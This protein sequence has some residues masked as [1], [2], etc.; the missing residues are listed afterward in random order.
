MV[1]KYCCPKPLY[2]QVNILIVGSKD[3]WLCKPKN[4][5]KVSSVTKYCCLKLC[6][7]KEIYSQW[8]AR[9]GGFV[10]PRIKQK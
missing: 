1:K 2:A 5:T 9:I 7:R 6:I 8:G 10:I 3:L 4:K